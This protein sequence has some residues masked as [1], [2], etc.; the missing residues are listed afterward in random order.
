MNKLPKLLFFPVLVALI[1]IAV[2]YRSRHRPPAYR[3]LVVAS[4][5]KD[6]VKMIDSARPM[7][8]R[9]AAENNFAF[10]FTKDTSVINDANLANYQVFVMLHLAPFDMSYAQQDAMQKFVEQGK[11]WV[12]IHAAG[13]TGKQFA[14]SK[15]YWEWFEHFMGDVTY[16]P[17]PKFQKGTLIFEDRTNPATKNMPPSIEISDEWY[18]WNK[19]AR[20]AVHILARADESTYIQ[21]KPMGDHPLI[22]TNEKYNM[23]YI[24]IGHDTSLCRNKDYQVLVRDAIAWTASR[25]AGK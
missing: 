11:G 15:K 20:G 2:A 8:E 1:L 10:D 4:L 9:L 5:A 23:I 16:S 12:G 19:S 18:E 14:P 6:H 25:A 22:W 3:V 24:G 13:L 21:N 7:F 17:H